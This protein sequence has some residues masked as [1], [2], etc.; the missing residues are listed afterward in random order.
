[1]QEISIKKY[2]EL[3]REECIEAILNVVNKISDLWIL[4]EIYRFSVNI[5]E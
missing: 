1:M 5:T 2:C 3:D 4:W